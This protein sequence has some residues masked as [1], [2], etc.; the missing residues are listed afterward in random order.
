MRGRLVK[1]CFLAL[2]AVLLSS[3]V[4]A[5]K[6]QEEEVRINFAELQAGV[7]SLADSWLS[8]SGQGFE[9][10][11]ESTDD[12]QVRLRVRQVRYRSWSSVVDI[13]TGPWPGTAML[14]M[15]VFSSLSRATW[16]R[17]WP[18]EFPESGALLAQYH[19]EFEEEAWKFGAR[20]LNG[21]Q[22]DQIRDRIE[23]WLA[24]NPEARQANMIRFTDFGS[25]GNSPDFRQE[26]QPG[27]LLSPV[28][29]AAAA[30]EAIQE[31]SERAMFLAMRM[32]NLMADRAELTVA[33]ILAREDIS[34]LLSDVSGFQDVA[35]DYA[36]IM[37]RMPG[38][39]ER[40][41]HEGLADIS[42]EREATITQA[43]TELS[44]EREAA[45]VQLLGAV[46]AERRAALEQVLTGVQQERNEMINLVLDLVIWADLQ[47]KATFAR[48][49]VLSACLVLLYFILRLVYR[50]MRDRENFNFRAA[51]STIA[52][53]WLTA[54]SIIAI[55]VLFVEF[56][57][58]DM[59]RIKEME[60][61]L[62]AAQ[63]QIEAS[64]QQAAESVSE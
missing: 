33:S 39:V 47:A 32:Q 18:T 13:A 44:R 60:Q 50:Y 45:I 64:Q 26:T 34:Q 10:I 8:L 43:M 20:Y 38:D 6:K 11:L 17:A 25:L 58:P 15:M 1:L 54:I 4:Q 59:N 22:L 36:R 7:M 21:A 57:K 24:Q 9:R 16:D 49:F 14:D 3:P 55:G 61:E 27:G 19:S 5:K 51:V 48:I 46:S 35:E 42:E 53:L 31:T 29:D 56:S 62:K 23:S 30:A 2:G 12:T 52:L 63:A 40:I 41:I 28:R 37:D